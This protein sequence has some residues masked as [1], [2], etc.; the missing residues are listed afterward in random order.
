M[1]AYAGRTTAVSFFKAK[2][3]DNIKTLAELGAYSWSYIGALRGKEHDSS[4]TTAD[5]TTADSPDYTKESI[6]TFKEETYK[7]DGVARDEEIYN[8][9]KLRKAI[10]KPDAVSQGGEPYF[11]L[12]VVDPVFGT[13]YLFVQGTKCTITSAHDDAIKF[14]VE[15]AVMNSVDSE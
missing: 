12:K 6:V 5:A 4:W 8:V 13:E 10:R 1:S 7:A 2:A 14:S 11:W 15:F 9:K 3:S